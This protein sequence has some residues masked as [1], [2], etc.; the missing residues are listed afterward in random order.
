[1]SVLSEILGSFLGI[2]A[3]IWIVYKMLKC[4]DVTVTKTTK[5]NGKIVKVEKKTEPLL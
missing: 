5:I 2:S 4:V 1:M 3:A